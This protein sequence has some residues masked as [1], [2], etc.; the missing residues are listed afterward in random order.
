MISLIHKQIPKTDKISFNRRIVR[1]NWDKIKIK[2]RTAIDCKIH[3]KALLQNV[4]HFRLLDEILIDMECFIENP[5]AEAIKKPLTSFFLFFQAKR[6]EIKR[7]NP[8]CDLVIIII[9]SLICM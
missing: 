8:G 1:L 5:T 7:N 9:L 6:E 4:R 2:G 3:F